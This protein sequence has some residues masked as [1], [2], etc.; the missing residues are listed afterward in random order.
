MKQIVQL[1]ARRTYTEK[2]A[3]RKMHREDVGILLTGDADVYRP[4]GSPLCFLRK[5]AIPEDVAE[6]A[7]PAL[8]SLRAYKSNNRG[9]Y[10][11]EQRV[12]SYEGSRNT[13]TSSVAS[14]IVGY[15]DRQGG[16]HPYCRQT[17]FTA[18][19]VEKWNTIVPMTRVVAK[20]FEECLPT[21]F[22]RQMSAAQK[23]H[24][25]WVIDGTPYST[26]TV[27]NNVVAATHRD[28]GDF[29]EGFGCI[30]V[31]RRGQYDGAILMFPEYGVGVELDD[32]DVFL[33]DP[34]AWHAVTPFEN[35]E[36][37]YERI[38]VVYYFREKIL[39]CGTPAE[40]LA[41]AQQVSDRAKRK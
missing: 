41:N 23:S 17:A 40:E 7:Y 8:H 14:A 30:S 31:A 11:G 10:S 18:N 21:H 38:S 15:F 1:R 36:E 29:K 3:G 19:E 16:R 4:D 12:A 25:A 35:T 2:L 32:R 33:F 24:P 28:K 5:G 34:H 27:N 22:A 6:A 37:G 26:L 20:V 13:G 39:N 9:N